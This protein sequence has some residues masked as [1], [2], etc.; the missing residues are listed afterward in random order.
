M[1]DLKFLKD[2]QLHECIQLISFIKASVTSPRKGLYNHETSQDSWSF[3]VPKERTIFTKKEKEQNRNN[4]KRPQTCNITKYRGTK[5]HALKPSSRLRWP[6]SH[7]WRT[8]YN[9]NPNQKM[10]RIKM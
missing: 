3:N 5:H 9:H 2:H 7:G 1:T 4:G 10:E 8:N 6:N